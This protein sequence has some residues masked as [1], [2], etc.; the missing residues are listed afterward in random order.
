[1]GLNGV[2]LGY[3]NVLGEIICDGTKLT[4]KCLISESLMEFSSMGYI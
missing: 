1:M 3:K 2:C 4:L